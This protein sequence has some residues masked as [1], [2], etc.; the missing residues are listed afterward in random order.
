MFAIRESQKEEESFEKIA[1][2][3]EKANASPA[4]ILEALMESIGEFKNDLKTGRTLAK[5]QKKKRSEKIS[6]ELFEFY[7]PQVEPLGES[8]RRQRIQLVPKLM[9]LEMRGG[10]ERWLEFKVGEDRLY[11]LKDPLSFLQCVKEGQSWPLGTKNSIDTS[12]FVWADE[13]SEKLFKLIDEARQ[14]E[15]DLMSCSEFGYYGYGYYGRS[16]IFE[17][18]KFKLGQENFARFLEIMAGTPFEFNMDNSQTETVETAPGNPPF[19]LTVEREE[20]GGDE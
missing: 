4:Q 14:R 8:R 12:S 2:H 9:V 6:R 7:A 18:K 17:A 5:E 20:D 10:Y 15:R 11:V 19:L 13:T 1:R 3:I 16:L